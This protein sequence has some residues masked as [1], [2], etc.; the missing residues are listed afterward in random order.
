[1]KTKVMFV[2][3]VALIVVIPF[4]SA[5]QAAPPSGIVNSIC[6]VSGDKVN[7]EITYEHEGKTYGFCCK[8]CINK[9]K[10][11]PEKYI[12][13]MSAPETSNGGE[14]AGHEH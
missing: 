10:K 1:M 14:H 13:Q 4:A 8:G 3:L 12:A 6:P 11:D 9:F 2:F 7:P 5:E